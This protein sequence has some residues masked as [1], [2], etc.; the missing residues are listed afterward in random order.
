M[1]AHQQSIRSAP[2]RFPWRIE[3]LVPRDQSLAAP[4]WFSANVPGN[5]R[6]GIDALNRLPGRDHCV[7]S[8][9]PA[10]FDDAPVPDKA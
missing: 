4:K 10:G 2:Y 5:C 8:L 7:G 9:L 1:S 6:Q 3:C